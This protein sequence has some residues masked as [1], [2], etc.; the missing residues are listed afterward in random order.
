[1]Y[2]IVNDVCVQDN[3]YKI[4]ED[5]EDN[6]VQD[7]LKVSCLVAK[8]SSTFHR[9]RTFPVLLLAAR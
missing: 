7:A 8:D 3:V 2:K 9:G 4:G 6:C 5:V 1:M